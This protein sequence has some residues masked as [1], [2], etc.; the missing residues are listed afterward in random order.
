MRIFITRFSTAVGSLLLIIGLLIVSIEMF[1]LNPNFFES[2]YKALDT[3]ASIGLEQE[4]LETITHNLLDYTAGRRL[5]LDMQAVIGGEEQ[6]VFGAREKEHMV[7][8]R[9]LYQGARTVRT[10]SPHRRCGTAYPCVCAG[11]QAG[12]ENTVPNIP[13]GI[14]RV[15]RG[16]CRD[17]DI[18]RT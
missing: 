15:R 11:R 4:D 18:C 7:D 13:L 9:A 12:A 1:A 3:A 8:V 17:R 14:G 6:E 10:A 16:G 2:E 5:S